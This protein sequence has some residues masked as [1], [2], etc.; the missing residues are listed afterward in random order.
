MPAVGICLQWASQEANFRLRVWI[1]WVGTDTGQGSQ[2][3]DGTQGTPGP[4]W[5]EVTGPSQQS[6][7]LPLPLEGGRTRSLPRTRSG[8][9]PRCPLFPAP[10]SELKE[11]ANQISQR[12]NRN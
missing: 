12:L 11:I 1:S 8:L 5:A 7:G 6:T 3:L 2:G 9:K 4:P 10:P